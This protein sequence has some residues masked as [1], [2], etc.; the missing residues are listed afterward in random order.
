MQKLIKAR[1]ENLNYY[2]F[3]LGLGVA[4][5]PPPSTG[6]SAKTEGAA[7]EAAAGGA[8]QYISYS[9]PSAATS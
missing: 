4:S 2:K 8:D 6:K 3:G 9:M 1:N 7:S 5:A